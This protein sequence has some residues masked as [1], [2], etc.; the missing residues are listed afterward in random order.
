MG[1]LTKKQQEFLLAVES[2]DSVGIR[3]C[4]EEGAKELLCVIG[5]A[6]AISLKASPEIFELLINENSPYELL[7]TYHR[8]KPQQAFETHN[9]LSGTLPIPCLT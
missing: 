1:E 9:H 8:A 5:K 7:R 3:L 4:L 6:C 2:K